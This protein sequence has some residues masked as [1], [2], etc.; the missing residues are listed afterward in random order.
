M[1]IKY[2]YLKTEK[3]EWWMPRAGQGS[4]ELVFNGDRISVWEGKISGD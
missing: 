3:E 1:N 4:G 2:K